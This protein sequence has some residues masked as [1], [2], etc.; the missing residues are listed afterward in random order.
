M[1]KLVVV[2]QTL[3]WW[4]YCRLEVWAV[5]VFS[6]LCGLLSLVILWSEVTLFVQHPV[7]SII[8]LITH[9]AATNVIVMV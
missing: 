7:L 6:V 8:E 5:R 3:K 4:W 9:S 2:K 1:S